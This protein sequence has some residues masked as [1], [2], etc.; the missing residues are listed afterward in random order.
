MQ[1]EDVD[2]WLGADVE[3]WKTDYPKRIVTLFAEDVGYRDH[4]YDAPLR[5][6]DA[7]ASCLGD[8]EHAGASTRD[9]PGTLRRD[10]P[11]HRRRR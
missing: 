3:A 10:L 11:G 4:P 8:G 5:G 6:R 2:R 7:V 9:E 1:R